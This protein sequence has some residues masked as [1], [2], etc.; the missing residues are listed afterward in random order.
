MRDIDVRHALRRSLVERFAAESDTLIVEEFGLL[1]GSARI[2]MAAI[3]GALHGYEIKSEGDTLHRLP[4]QVELYGRVF[5]YVT[6]V[7]SE[8]HGPTSEDIVPD[9]WGINVACKSRWV[10][11]EVVR[12]A[13]RNPVV[14]PA[15]VAGLLWRSEL[16]SILEA[17]GLDAGVRSATRARMGDRLA[18][19]LV[20]GELGCVVRDALRARSDWRARQRRG[21]SGGSSLP[22]AMSSSFRSL[23]ARQ[24]SERCSRRR[25]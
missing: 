10:S 5:D 16:L 13:Y 9:W 19:S 23:R 1:E 15:S 11:L 7:R 17:R 4:R 21:S 2:D 18:A 20:A 8:R 24:P 6:L 25:G 3:N 12:D 14:D 22:F